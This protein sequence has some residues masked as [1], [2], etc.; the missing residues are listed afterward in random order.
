MPTTSN[1]RLTDATLDA[2]RD[3]LLALKDLADYRPVNPEHSVESLTALEQSLR[4]A[5]ETEAR[6][7]KSLVAA[8][9][10]TIQ[11]GRNFHQTVQ[12]AKDQVM[13]QYGRDSLA[14]RSIGLTRRSDRRRAV[15]RR[16]ATQA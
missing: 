8:R 16:G 14:I 12:G 13:A 11:A 15:R 2:D 3:A 5:E 7:Q 6:I 9:D 1:Y 10:A 4:Q